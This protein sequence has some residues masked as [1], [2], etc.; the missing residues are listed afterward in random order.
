MNGRCLPVALFGALMG[1]NLVKGVQVAVVISAGLLAVAAA[2]AAF[3]IAPATV[4]TG[5]PEKQSPEPRAIG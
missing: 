4:V 2:F 5:E 1:G 3:G